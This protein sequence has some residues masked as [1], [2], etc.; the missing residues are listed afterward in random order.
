[1]HSFKKDAVKQK[2]NIDGL[3]KDE[4]GSSNKF[5]NGSNMN[6]GNFTT[7]K[8]TTRVVAP[9]GGKSQICFF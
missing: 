2:E 6:S 7:D 9:P 8:P 5:A 1:M 3:L 4:R